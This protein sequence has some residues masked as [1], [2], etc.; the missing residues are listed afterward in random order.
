MLTNHSVVSLCTVEPSNHNTYTVP[1]VNMAGI[2]FF[3]NAITQKIVT[4][5]IQ[6]TIPSTCVDLQEAVEA[7]KKQNQFLSAELLEMN[8]LRSD[9]LTVNRQLTQLVLHE[10]CME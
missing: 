2:L 7:Y 1:I 5:H 10:C 6:Y 9:D 8:Q 3:C 4:L